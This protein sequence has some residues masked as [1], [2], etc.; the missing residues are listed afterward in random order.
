M[1]AVAVPALQHRLLLTV[2]EAVAN[3]GL[4]EETL[5]LGLGIVRELR[6][7]VARMHQE[8]VHEL[9]AGVEGRSFVRS[10]SPIRAAADEYLVS[11]GQLLEALSA[12]E[13]TPAESFVTE[14]RLLEQDSKAFRDRIAQALS[15]ASRPHPVVDWESLQRKSDAEFAAGRF[16]TIASAEELRKRLADGD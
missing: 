11:L 14:L 10:Y 16:T 9:A 8:L 15:A 7:S 5:R 4:D 12:A 13:G 1:T 3:G 6:E 2:G